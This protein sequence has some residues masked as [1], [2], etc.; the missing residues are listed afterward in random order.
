MDTRLPGGKT[1]N[2]NTTKSEGASTEDSGSIWPVTEPEAE[3]LNAGYFFGGSTEG[4]AF[5]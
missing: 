4:S 1:D 3:T 2:A 5:R